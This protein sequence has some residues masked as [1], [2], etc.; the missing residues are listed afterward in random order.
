VANNIHVKDYNGDEQIV[1]TTDNGGVQTPHHNVDLMPA[2]PFGANAD[3]A[4]VTDVAGTWSGKLR[5]LVK[6]AF[7][8]MPAAL[9]RLA[10]SDSLPVVIS[11]DPLPNK[12]STVNS[13]TATLGSGASFTGTGEDLSNYQ[14]VAVSVI[15][16]EASAADGLKIEFSSDNTNW[17]LSHTFTVAA[18]V[19]RHYTFAVEAK[20]FRV[21]YINGGVSQSAF[22]LQS[23][24]LPTLPGI[25]TVFPADQEGLP[26]D[27]T[28]GA[29]S[30]TIGAVNLAQYTPASGRL[31]VDGSG[32]T[33]PVS[34]ASLPLPTGAATS[35]NQSSILTAVQNLLTGTI[36][37][38]GSAF[39]G[40]TGRT[41]ATLSASP[42]V[43]TAIYASGDLIGGKLSFTS[44]VL[45]SAG[46]G[47]ILNCLLADQAKQDAEI[48]L[49][50]FDADPTG[51]TFTDQAALDIA[52]A[53]LTKIIGIYRFSDY[54]DFADNA[55]AQVTLASGFKLASGTT[56]FGALVSR[57]TPTYV[58]GTDVTVRISVIQN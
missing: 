8:R 14:G 17:D 41:H 13:S 43:D 11:S 48:D 47:E 2:D 51:T 44:A 37:A 3:S 18:D 28:L 23:I 31:P 52:D 5:G 1:K 50:L 9:G 38:A 19:A 29:G 21:R 4:V 27:V 25:P 58:A 34:A 22:R 10:A 24:L 36:L 56:L 30:A 35:A 53:D 55:I 26:I 49:V 15:A 33:Q 57:G 7:E 39:I 46:G 40:K 32:V 20:W 16:D 42:T 45:A 54:A 6:W 12:V